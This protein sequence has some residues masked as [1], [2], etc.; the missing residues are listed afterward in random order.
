MDLER[1]AQGIGFLNDNYF[2]KSATIGPDLRVVQVPGARSMCKRLLQNSRSFDSNVTFC[3]YPKNT[4]AL[5][6]F[7]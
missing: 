2:L 7:S 5:L 3:I 6:V 1:A 4:L